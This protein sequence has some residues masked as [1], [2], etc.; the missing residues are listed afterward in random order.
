MNVPQVPIYVT[1]LPDCPTD[2]AKFKAIHY[3]H[4][5]SL[6]VRSCI[7]VISLGIYVLKNY[8]NRIINDLR[9]AEVL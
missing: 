1:L 2:S 7:Q 6:Q 8:L 5:I 4:R 3:H 9:A